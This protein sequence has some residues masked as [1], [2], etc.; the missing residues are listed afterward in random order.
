MRALG[1]FGGRTGRM[2]AHF[3]MRVRGTWSC[4]IGAGG[5]PHPKG[6]GPLGLGLPA[7]LA[8]EE[9]RRVNILPARTPES[10]SSTA[11]AVRS[12]RLFTLPLPRL[13]ILRAT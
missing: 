3:I 2:R 4:P 13:L 1:S 10:Q 8:E 12:L 5:E 11:W 7:C 6:E 9:R